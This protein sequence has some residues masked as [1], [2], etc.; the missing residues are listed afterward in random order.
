MK[1]RSKFDI[2]IA[3]LDVVSGGATKTKIVYKA[4]LNFNLATKYL[5]LL[6][7]KGL[8]R[9]DGSSYEIT[10]DGKTFVEKARELQI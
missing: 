8:V 10:E 6:L 9:V 3:I 2:I 7:E 5:E 1:R 4:N